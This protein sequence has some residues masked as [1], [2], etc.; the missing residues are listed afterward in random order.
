M[1]FKVTKFVVIYYQ[2]PQECLRATVTKEFQCPNKINLEKQCCSD[3]TYLL[4]GSD[5]ELLRLLTQTSH[6][7]PFHIW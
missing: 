6:S 2:Q 7:P 3:E 1:L 5:L 4:R